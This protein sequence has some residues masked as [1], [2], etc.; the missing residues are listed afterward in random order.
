MPAG[1][2]RVEETNE[3]RQKSLPTDCLR[4]RARYRPWESTRKKDR[5]K[6]CMFV[7]SMLCTNV[8]DGKM[9]VWKGRETSGKKV[10]EGGRCCVVVGG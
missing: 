4:A 9:F 2:R 10:R 5:E 1:R 8:V 6:A 7:L 3:R